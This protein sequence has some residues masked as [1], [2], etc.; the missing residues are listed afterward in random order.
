V[1]VA[2]KRKADVPRAFISPRSPEDRK[3]ARARCDRAWPHRPGTLVTYYPVRKRGHLE[4][5]PLQTSTR[6]G[7]FLDS[8]GDIVVFLTDKPGYVRVAHLELREP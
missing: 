2:V 3:A 4:G 5:D 8:D 6:S 1:H 7:S